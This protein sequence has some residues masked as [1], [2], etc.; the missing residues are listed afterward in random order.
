M[1]GKLYLIP[2]HLG[3]PQTG[4]TIP[5]DVAQITC[6]LEYY[7]VENLRTARRYLKLLDKKKNIDNATFYLMDKHADAGEYIKFLEP[8]EKGYDVGIISEAGCP[9]VADPGA[10]IVKIAHRKN[11]EV[12]PLTG[13]SSLLLALMASGLNGQNFAFNGYLPINKNERAKTIKQLENKSIKEDQTQIFIEAPYRNMA[14]V[15]EI[16]KQC[17]PT[18]LLCIACDLTLPE[19]FVLTLPVSDWKNQLPDL[20]KKPAIFLVQG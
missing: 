20:H 5:P 19:E 3:N 17:H 1:Q 4:I 6:K 18:T 8:I 16:L 10:E 7:I 13:P 12:V 11:I 9:G 15:K 2:N 14:M